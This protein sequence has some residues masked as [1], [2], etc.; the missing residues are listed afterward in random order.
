MSNVKRVTV[1]YQGENY[2]IQAVL[3]H[4]KTMVHRHAFKNHHLDCKLEQN[5]QRKDTVRMT[6][7]RHGNLNTYTSWEI[8]PCLDSKAS[9]FCLGSGTA[10]AP[11]GGRDGKQK[12]WPEG[13]AANTLNMHITARR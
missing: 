10:V 7:H 2:I 4:I 6:S 13:R 8:S 3:C 5:G 12:N 11:S 9:G 1:G